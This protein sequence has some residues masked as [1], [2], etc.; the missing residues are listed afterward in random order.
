FIVQEDY[1]VFAR[2]TTPQD[3]VVRWDLVA[4]G[5]V[6]ITVGDVHVAPGDYVVAD[7]DGI[8]VIPADVVGPVL[9]ETEAKVATESEIRAAVRAGT[10]PLEAYEKYGTF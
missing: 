1:P 7:W 9:E 10:L 6:T 3:C 8:V 2:H 4:H 5:D